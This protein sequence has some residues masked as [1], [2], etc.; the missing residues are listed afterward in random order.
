MNRPSTFET[1]LRSVLSQ[2][3][4][5]FE[6][7]AS[8]NSNDTA[9]LNSNAKVIEYNKGDS[10]IR[11]I[12]PPH[13]MNMVDHWEFAS[14]QCNGRYVLFLTDRFVMCASALEYLYFQITSATSDVNLIAWNT[15]SFNLPGLVDAPVSSGTVTVLNSIAFLNDFSSLASWQTALAWNSKLP[16]VLNSC[17]SKQIADRILR[18]H[19]RLFRPASPDYTAGYTLLANTPEFMYCDITLYL[20]HGSE[21]N[22]RRA[23]IKGN[24]HYLDTL[25]LEGRDRYASALPCTLPTVTNLILTDLL[26]I[27]A[28]ENDVLCDLQFIPINILM[29]NYCELIE[30]ERLG[31][32]IDLAAL[33]HHWWNNVSVL[34][35]ADQL[36]V[37][38]H[39]ARIKMQKIRFIALRRWLVSTGLDQFYHW[40]IVKFREFRERL[41]GRQLYTDVFDAAQSRDYFIRDKCRHR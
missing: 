13:W 35:S 24:D 38:S 33:Y 25:K 11:Y 5:D 17:Y 3:Y 16:R 22:G 2:T 34:S 36:A 41:A 20:S 10:R 19:G 12:R 30:M 26:L 31:S 8:D 29:A 28:I 27:Q 15:G 18:K 21:S 1:A 32:Q 6:V 39:V 14:S 4:Q 7:I 23:L 40:I 37:N 9:S